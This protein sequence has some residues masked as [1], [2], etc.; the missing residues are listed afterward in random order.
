MLFN[1]LEY[2]LFFISILGITWLVIG[3]PKL[4][5]WILLIASYYF[6]TANN[7]W[8]ILLIL[9]STQVDFYAARKIE[10]SRSL[11]ERKA[12][13][14][15]SIV[16]NLGILGFFKY[17]NF[18]V[19][20]VVSL[21]NVI[22][23]EMSWVDLN[24][25]LPV[26][27]SFYTF[28]SMAYT[29]DVYRMDIKAERSWL[30]FSFFIAYFPQLIAGPIIR[31]QNFLPQLNNKLYLNRNDLHFAL[32]YISK[33]LI[34]KIV[35]AD[36]LSGV[37]DGVFESNG[38][39][40]FFSTLIALYA[41]TFQIYFD[42]SG[43]S[44]V[45]IGCSKLLGYNI[46]ENFRRP[47]MATSITDFW[48]RWHISLSGWL[49]DYLYKSLGGNRMKSS[50][51]VYRNLML[52]MVLGGLWHGA[53]WH[54]VIWG[55]FQGLILSI[56]RLLSIGN[57]ANVGVKKPH[58]IALFFKWLFTFHLVVFSWGIF[59]VGDERLFQFLASFIDFRDKYIVT[60]GML[61]TI[62]ILLVGLMFQFVTE[63]FNIYDR[64]IGG[65]VFVKAALYSC[66][67]ILIFIFA[68]PVAKPFIY[69]QF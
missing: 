68:S 41:F 44:D 1:S 62:L 63:N 61:A 65:P 6:Y 66:V 27:I 21:A 48:R 12:L 30:R 69:F 33:G 58:P 5:L 25:V 26:G 7:G 22:G 49:R 51:G 19:S 8:L 35:F 67:I 14:T 10:V 42:F 29:I 20:S 3:V 45:A 46:P 23:W 16:I 31:P 56:E 9:I 50:M 15:I 32:L 54:F 53:A 57:K 13:L 11:T 64:L 24:L 17:F 38:N 47:Y 59:R 36:M 37:A 4:R 52:T 39:F 34:K 18:F 60:G 28:Q 2:L 40:D 55:W 43:Y